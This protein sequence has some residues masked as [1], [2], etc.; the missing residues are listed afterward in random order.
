MSRPLTNQFLRF[1]AVG[2]AGFVVDASVLY[3]VAGALGLYFGRVLSFWAAAT[4]TW[5]LNRRF[6][7]DSSNRAERRWWREYARYIASMLAGAV[8]NYLA[9]V[10]ALRWG[11]APVAAVALGSLAGMTLNFCS[12]RWMVFKQ[13]KENA[14]CKD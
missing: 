3:A 6:T 12:A 5:L 2:A 8:L 13:E 7:F 4:F 10:A 9:Y 1:A 11:M 14:P